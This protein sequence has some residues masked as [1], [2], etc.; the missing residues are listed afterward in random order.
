MVNSVIND[1]LIYSEILELAYNEN[2]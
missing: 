2:L 1:L